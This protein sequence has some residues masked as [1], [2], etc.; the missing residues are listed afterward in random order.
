M[1]YRRILAAQL[2]NALVLYAFGELGLSS[3][4]ALSSVS[5]YSTG[6][7]ASAKVLKKAIDS[8]GQAALQLIE[9]ATSVPQRAPEQTGNR[10]NISA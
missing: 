8:E 5:S 6:E 3:I 1:R 2:R 7:Q 9:S 10:I 4:S